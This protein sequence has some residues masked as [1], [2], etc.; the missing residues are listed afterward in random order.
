M[1]IIKSTV[2]VGQKPPKEVIQEIR[3]AA[4][5]PINYT[6]E[7]PPSSPEALKEFAN[8]ATERNKRKKKQSVTIRVAPDVLDSYKTM[9]DGYTGIMAD[10]LKYAVDNPSILTKATR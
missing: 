9:G 8:L 4:K 1:G 7:F 2:K 3:K 5:Q 10:V 6:E